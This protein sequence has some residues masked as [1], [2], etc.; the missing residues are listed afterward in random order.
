MTE[1][2]RLRRPPPEFRRGRVTGVRPITPRL[3]RVTVAG[4]DLVGFR[5]DEP[6]ASLRLLLPRDGAGG[7]LEV[8][9]WNGNE[10]LFADGTRPPIR[11]LTPL[12]HDP[13]AGRIDVEV[14]LHGDDGA[15]SR[16]A[17]AGPDGDEVAI[18]GPG[19]GYEVDPAAAAF[20][21]VGD[22]SALP[23]IV[24]LLGALP[25]DADV[26]VIVEVADDD[27]R[28]ELPDHPRLR[29]S[30]LVAAPTEPPG[31]AL[32]RAV[33]DAEPGAEVRVWAAAEAAAVQ[34]LRGVVAAHGIPRPHTVIRGYW[35]HGRPG[36]GS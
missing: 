36:A 9:E 14:V 11:T 12:D 33:A 29:S 20:L 25:A 23:A 15:L 16:W 3:V 7:A 8:P 10:F 28:V 18:S 26:E 34:S 2:I 19:R 32:V 30:W 24:Q 1:P 31:T 4:P 35:K 22:E 6:A 13:E 27:A 5:V 21:L 17:A